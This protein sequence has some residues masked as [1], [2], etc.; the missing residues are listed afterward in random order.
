MP[1]IRKCCVRECNNDNKKCNL[2][3]WPKNEKIA[4]K[5]CRNLG[6]EGRKIATTNTFVCAM[7]FE[8]YALGAKRL[9]IGA[10]PTLKLGKSDDAVYLSIKKSNEVRTCC[11][12][13]CPSDEKDILFAFPD[14]EIDFDNWVLALKISTSY[15]D[16]RK[17]F[18]CDRHFDVDSIINKKLK[19]GA[20]PKH[21]L[22][23]ETVGNCSS[24]SSNRVLHPSKRQ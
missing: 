6:F 13:G 20:I 7:H 15:S 17:L 12:K 5:W 4:R 19:E 10:V 18:I 3:V 22:F 23:Y 21:N 2:F 1:R 11:A 24:F 9:K 14:D 8:D 16:R